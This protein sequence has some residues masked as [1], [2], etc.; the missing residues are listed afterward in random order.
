MRKRRSELLGVGI[1]A[2]I[3]YAVW[4]AWQST[5]AGA[6]D[7]TSRG[8]TAPFPFPPIPGP[9]HAA[10]APPA[11]SAPLRSVEP[12]GDGA[13]PATHPSRGS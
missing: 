9:H 12:N 7:A 1:L 5:S 2:G 6:P 8:T 11:E 3:A 13:C 10:P 4:R